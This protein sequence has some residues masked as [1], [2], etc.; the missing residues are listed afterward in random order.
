MSELLVRLAAFVLVGVLAGGLTLK[1]PMQD[2][3]PQDVES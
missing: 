3:G 1:C 2:H